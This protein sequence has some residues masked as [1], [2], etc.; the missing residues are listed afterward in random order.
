MNHSQTDPKL[1]SIVLHQW[2]ASP[3]CRKVAHMLKFKGLSYEVVNYNGLRGVMALRLS[4][5]G[6]LPVLDVRGLRVQDSTRIAR[7]LDEAFPDTPALYPRDPRTRAQAELWE[8]WADEVLY[9]FEGYFRLYDTKALEMFIAL[10]CE[11]RPKWERWPLKYL[12]KFAGS[13]SIKAQGLGRM[14]PENVKAEFLM[15][16]DRIEITLAESGWLVGKTQ[17]I[18]DMAVG[19]QMLEVVRTS[20]LREEILRRPN[21]SRWI[22]ALSS[23]HGLRIGT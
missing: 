7:Y 1:N 6:K 21:M 13:L 4:Q 12:L 9:W 16:L 14:K 19:S 2:E 20:Y 8:D 22:Q 10:M 5:V 11:G 15:H 23:P 17:T 3:F 18:A